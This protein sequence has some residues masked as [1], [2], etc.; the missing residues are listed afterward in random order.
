MVLV[1][2]SEQSKRRVRRKEKKGDNGKRRKGIC[3]EGK[4]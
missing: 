3:I 4:W 2:V 1:D